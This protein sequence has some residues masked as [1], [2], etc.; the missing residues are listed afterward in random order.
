MAIARCA[1]PRNLL[2]LT[3]VV[4]PQMMGTDLAEKLARLLP[5]LRVLFMSGYAHPLLGA[6][7]TLEPEVHLIQK[8]F[9]E[10]TLLEK[11]RE[12]LEAVP[13]TVAAPTRRSA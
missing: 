11:V 4:L 9:M 2:L 8:P 3:D 7:G 6:D 10:S 1:R 5:S 13:P 12:V